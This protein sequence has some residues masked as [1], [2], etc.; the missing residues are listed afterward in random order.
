M[1][2]NLQIDDYVISQVNLSS[3]EED[4]PIMKYG[5]PLFE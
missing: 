4:Q 3:E 1:S 5:Y 2:S